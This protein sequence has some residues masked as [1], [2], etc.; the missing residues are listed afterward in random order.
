MGNFE[1]FL[2]GIMIGTCASCAQGNL[3]TMGCANCS[4]P[5]CPKCVYKT[6]SKSLGDIKV[7]PK[8]R[9]SKQDA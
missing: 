6:K 8:C 7:C 4:K 2:Q 1:G 5:V 3:I 9:K